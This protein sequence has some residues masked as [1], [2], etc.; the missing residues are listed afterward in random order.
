[1]RESEGD[2]GVRGAGTGCSCQSQC[3]VMDGDGMG[4]LDGL[5]ELTSF[6]ANCSFTAVPAA[7]AL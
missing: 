3:A 2:G 5:S 1:M 4:A 6:P 7:G